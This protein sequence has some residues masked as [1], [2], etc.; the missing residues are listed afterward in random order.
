MNLSLGSSHEREEGWTTLDVDPRSGAD[1]IED[2]TELKTI[3]D[4]SCDEILACH[5]L[6]HVY[7]FQV[8]PTLELWYRKLKKGGKITLYLPDVMQFWSLFLAGKITHD[9]VLHV[10]YGVQDEVNSFAVHK[11]AFW[12]E[13]LREALKEVGFIRMTDIRPRYDTEFGI[14]AIKP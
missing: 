11:T 12:P 2:M 1:I 8:I 14:T 13:L 5:S 4:E 7:H 3:P 10:T 9:R 6:E